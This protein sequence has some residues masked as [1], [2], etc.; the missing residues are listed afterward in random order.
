MIHKSDPVYSF[1]RKT[2]HETRSVVPGPGNY[3]YNDLE[4]GPKYSF[5]KDDRQK[6]RPVTP[7]PGTY[8]DEEVYSFGHNAPK[9]SIGKSPRKE[10]KGMDEVPGPGQYEIKDSAINFTKDK[11]PAFKLSNASRDIKYK[12]DL[13]GP[14][15][16]DN[17]VLDSRYRHNP[18]WVMGKATRGEDLFSKSQVLAGPGSYTIQSTIGTAPKV[19]I[20]LNSNSI[21]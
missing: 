1:G 3:E 12:N 18:G 17:T 21:Q 8:N 16:Y 13:P 7:G 9:F 2:F 5:G 4:A 6:K 14:G 19:L 11:S 15:E 20:L 10:K